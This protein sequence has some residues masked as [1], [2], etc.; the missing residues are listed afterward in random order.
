MDNLSI[1]AV[2]GLRS[3]MVSLDLLANNLANAGTS[4]YKNDREFYGVYASEDAQNSV[5]GASGATLPVV[6]TQWTDFSAGEMQVTGNALDVAIV[7][8]GFF[9]VTGPKGPLYTRNG[10]LRIL[11]TGELANA[12]GYPLLSTGG[13]TIQV[14]PNAQISIASDGTVAQGGQ[15]LGQIGVVNFKST[16]SLR[17]IGS[18]SFENQSTTNLPSPATN[19]EVQQ[20]KLEG[21][22]VSVPDAAMRLVSVMRQFEMLQKAIGVSTDMDTKA[23]QEVARVSA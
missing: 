16:D 8:K 23:I 1:A 15:S 7:G 3:R 6:E 9:T 12:D 13:G 2:S 20:G 18:T 4:G 22:N 11:P 10:N 14:R 5:D 21:S 17:K 19:M